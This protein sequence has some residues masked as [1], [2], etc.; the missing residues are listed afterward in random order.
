MSPT[1][2]PP[3]E[4]DEC[5]ASAAPCSSAGSDLTSSLSS[6]RRGKEKVEIITGTPP[7][8]LSSD[9]REKVLT[10][11]GA[12]RVEIASFDELYSEGGGG[13]PEESAER[14]LASIHSPGCAQEKLDPKENPGRQY[15]VE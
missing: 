8:R 13:P 14:V 6:G 9:E 7:G 5:A 12:C 10:S 2:G 1:E 11:I 3:P 4:D 15:N